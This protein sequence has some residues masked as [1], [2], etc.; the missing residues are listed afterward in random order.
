MLVLNWHIVWTFVNIIVLFIFLKKFLF[1][2][3]TEMMEKRTKAI[4]DS[5]QE[6]ETK[7]TDAMKLKQ[8][9][10][11]ELNQAEKEASRIMKE[12]KERAAVEYNK[13]L[14]VAK[15]EAAKII[16][17]ANKTIEMERKKS[18]QNAQSEI[19][20]IALLAA[21]KVIGKNVDDNSNKQLLGDFIKEVG[22]AK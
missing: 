2:P 8:D 13:Q 19:A 18:I 15:E 10:E 3:V 12:A 6:A 20:G 1:G 21:S 17:D 14:L 7:K 5:I 22:A 11:E 9:Y 16:Q 4:E